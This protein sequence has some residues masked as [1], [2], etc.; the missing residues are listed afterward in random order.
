MATHAVVDSGAARQY[1][2]VMDAGDSA[3]DE[4]LAFAREHRL[5]TASFT[6]I[7]AFSDCTLAF[8]DVEAKQYLDNPVSQQSEVVSLTGN[9]VRTEEG[10]WQVHAH[11]V[12]A[13]RD[14]ATR[15]GHLRRAVVR[16]KLE[17]VVTE[18]THRLTRRFDPDSGLAFIDLG[19]GD[20]IVDP[21][22]LR[23]G[24]APGT[25]GS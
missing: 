19:S 8:Y 16:P 6:A 20:A 13:L 1:I 5:R 9:V 23:H 22:P 17:A 18:T 25:G 24:L 2:V 3:L 21:D 4:L 7:G 12:V 11:A 14:G 15:G 10:D